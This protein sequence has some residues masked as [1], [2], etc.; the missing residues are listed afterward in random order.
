[1]HR[2]LSLRLSVCLS[3]CLPSFPYSPLAKEPKVENRL[4]TFSQA[5]LD[6]DDDDDDERINFNVA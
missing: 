5:A 1:M 2:V 3:V 6:D 4:L